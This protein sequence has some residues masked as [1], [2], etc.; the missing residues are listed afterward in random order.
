V[1]VPSLY[2]YV[3]YNSD[4]REVVA[5]SAK[6]SQ[7]AQF[8]LRAGG[9]VVAPYNTRVQYTNPDQNLFSNPEL[10]TYECTNL[11]VTLVPNSSANDTFS[12]SFIKVTCA[13]SAGQG[14]DLYLRMQF[15]VQRNSATNLAADIDWFTRNWN[16]AGTEALDDLAH[17]G[18][19][20]RVG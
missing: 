8:T 19:N 2:G 7:T 13:L 4:T 14:G 3:V 18:D 1:N 12:N 20:N 6:G 10:L 11:V 9:N 15:C 5:D 16:W 17:I